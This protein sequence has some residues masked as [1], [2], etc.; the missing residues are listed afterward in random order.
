MW[1]TSSHQPRGEVKK[2]AN[3]QAATPVATPITGNRVD[4]VIVGSGASG[5]LLA[6]K[7][8]QSGKQVLI[9]ETGPAV[10]LHDLISSQIWARRLKWSGSF[11]ETG[12][13]NPIGVAFNS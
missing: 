5:S 8:A 11:T 10:A 12:G 13:A 3:T 7:L 6:A 9:L 1:P 4:A 2:M